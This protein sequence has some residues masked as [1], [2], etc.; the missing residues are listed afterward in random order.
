MDLDTLFR[1]IVGYGLATFG[2]IL[3]MVIV[4]RTTYLVLQNV[5]YISKSCIFKMKKIPSFLKSIWLKI[6]DYIIIACGICLYILLATLMFNDCFGN[7]DSKYHTPDE[8]EDVLQD[9]KW[10]V[11]SRYRE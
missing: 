3:I 9:G 7:S 10:N 11:P 6:K 2:A 8:Y 5:F 1:N 4:C